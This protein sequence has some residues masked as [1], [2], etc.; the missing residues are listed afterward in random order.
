MRATMLFVLCFS[1]VFAA[2]AARAQEPVKPGPEHAYFKQFDGVWN[3]TGKSFGDPN[4]GPQEF[5]GVAT[6]KLDVGGLWLVSDFR[7]DD[8]SG[9]GVAGYDPRT[10]KYTSIWVDS[11][12]TTIM[13]MEGTLDKSGKV[14]T[15]S[16]ETTGPD[17]KPM[18]LKLVTQIKDADTHVFT[19]SMPADG[20]DVPMLT[21]EYKRKK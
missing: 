11:M 19:M 12:S 13:R 18:K 16:A 14:M 1:T 3:A 21:I 7:T 9:H 15:E 10:K 6:Y 17:G 5:K 20:K 8:F 4:A 2:L